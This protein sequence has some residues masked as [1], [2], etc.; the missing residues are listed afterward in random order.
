MLSYQMLAFMLAPMF[1]SI[2]TGN[3]PLI[4]GGTILVA[5]VGLT[6]VFGIKQKNE[7]EAN[8]AQ[9]VKTKTALSL[10]EKVFILYTLLF[11]AIVN[12]AASMMVYIL[13]E[14]YEFP[15]YAVKSGICLMIMSLLSGL[16]ILLLKSPKTDVTE[17]DRAFEYNNFRPGLQFTI[18]LATL[19]M[20]LLLLLKLSES[21][22]FVAAILSVLGITNGL[23]LSS[24][25]KFAGNISVRENRKDLLTVFNNLQSI[26]S[27]AAYGI[28]IGLSVV[29]RVYSINFYA[30][31]ILIII[32]ALLS[33]LVLIFTWLHFHKRDLRI[34]TN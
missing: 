18:V 25:R 10:K 8:T 7:H 3:M 17:D 12:M 32:A 1:F 22:F 28:C 21:F 14:Y 27:L 2:S 29:A 16:G 6:P 19:A 13:A 30:F 26:S 34:S 33:E 24:T 23:F 9:S 31:L 5:I 11:M 20:T 15:N 4:L